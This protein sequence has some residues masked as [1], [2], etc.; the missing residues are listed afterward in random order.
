MK[1]IIPMCG[2]EPHNLDQHSLLLKSLQEIDTST[3]LQSLQQCSESI[4]HGVEILIILSK[5]SALDNLWDSLDEN[6]RLIKVVEAP[7]HDICTCLLA[8]EYW[9]DDEEI[10]IC[11]IEQ[12]LENELDKLIGYFRMK[13]SGLGVVSFGASESNISYI[14]RD[15]NHS[16]IEVVESHSKSNDVLEY[17]FFFNRASLFFK[18]ATSVILKKSSVE[19]SFHLSA[20]INEALLERVQVDVYQR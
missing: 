18:L 11:N 9:Q 8:S 3:M 12:C 15:N 13:G 17:L 7:P 6:V 5:N 16:I 14:K 20:C 2:K 10:V 4:K 1:I 19:D